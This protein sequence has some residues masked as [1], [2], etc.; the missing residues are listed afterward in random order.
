MTL[1]HDRALIKAIDEHPNFQAPTSGRRARRVTTD[2]LINAARIRVHEADKP[3]E[4]QPGDEAIFQDSS[5][6]IFVTLIWPHPFRPDKWIV[7]KEKDPLTVD[8]A[9]LYPRQADQA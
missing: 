4:P 7:L 3:W 1:E 6:L 8:V 9:N 2:S 5:H